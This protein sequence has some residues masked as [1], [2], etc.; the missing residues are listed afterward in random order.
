MCPARGKK[1]LLS[2][3][4]PRFHPRTSLPVVRLS[5]GAGQI[6]A[7]LNDLGVSPVYGP[8]WHQGVVKC[9]LSNIIY[10]GYP[11]YNKASNSRFMEFVDGQVKTADRSKPA[12]KRA[13]SDQ[14]RPDEPEF[15]AIVEPEVF[16]QAQA[17]P[18]IEKAIAEK[19]AELETLLDGFAGLSPKLNRI[20]QVLA[21]MVRAIT[22]IEHR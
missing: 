6:A 20:M 3:I 19:E 12:R 18:R 10:T 5:G 17:K 11:V 15:P 22:A 14:V 1:R 4:I 16:D 7:R 8:L 9:L 21:C 13:E 2:E